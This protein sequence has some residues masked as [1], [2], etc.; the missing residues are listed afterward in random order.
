V[1]G[2]E[3][4]SA[5]IVQQQIEAVVEELR[6]TAV[7]TGMLYSREIVSVVASALK[8][9]CHARRSSVPTGGVRSLPLVV[10]PVMVSTSGARLMELAAITI[11]KE[12]LLPLASLVTPNLSEAEILTGQNIVSVED[13]RRAAKEIHGQFGCA[14]LVKGGHLTNSDEAIDIF[15]DG[16]AELLLSAPFIRGIR[17]HGTGC[18]Y[19][20]AICAA[21]ARGNKLPSAVR[22]GKELVTGAIAN[23]YRVKQHFVLNH[24]A[25]E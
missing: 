8:S 12:Q 11:L 25:A 23:S 19:S 1:L 13:M 14:V 18:T 20:A 16:K 9:Y 5:E 3:P 21:L 4:V 10:D 22:I 7:K 15:F 6:P 2:I 24:L 17:T